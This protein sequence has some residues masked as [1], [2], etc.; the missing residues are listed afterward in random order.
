VRPQR[1][2]VR[3]VALGDDVPG[4]V[5]GQPLQH[6]HSD[7]DVDHRRVAD[8]VRPL[9]LGA[10]PIGHLAG[11]AELGLHRPPAEAAD[12][13]A[14]QQRRRRLLGRA[15]DLRIPGAADGR[16]VR[17]SRLE[18]LGH[19]TSSAAASCGARDATA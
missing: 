6:E 1:V 3:T 19:D 16:A 7:P 5:A 15:G 10:A 18:V 12:G 11:L 4:V 2:Q 13:E 9:A 8:Q 17:V 14:G